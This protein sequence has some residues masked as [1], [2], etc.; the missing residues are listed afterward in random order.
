MESSGYNRGGGDYNRDQNRGGERQ[1]FSDRRPIGGQHASFYQ[2]HERYE[3]QRYD[4]DDK[5]NHRQNRD[6]DS[7][8]NYRENR[9]RDYRPRDD[10][11]PLD[12]D[13][14]RRDMRHEAPS[15][16][17]YRGGPST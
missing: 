8:D 7:R 15:R 1:D 4:R 16:D 11:R 9:P 13:Y 3:E 12:N 14:Q 2:N 17:P 5:E 10:H 6:I